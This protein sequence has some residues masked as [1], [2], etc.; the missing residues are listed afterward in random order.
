MPAGRLRDEDG[1]ATGRTAN[2]CAS[3]AFVTLNRLVAL[4]AG[5]FEIGHKC[6]G[7]NVL[8]L[9]YIIMNL[10]AWPFKYLFCPWTGHRDAGR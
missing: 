8:A 4:R 1:L 6:F 7:L 10:R 2:L 3:V 5:K 9:F